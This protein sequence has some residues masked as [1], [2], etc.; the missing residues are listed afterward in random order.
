MP[1]AL[2]PSAYLIQGEGQGQLPKAMFSFA[3]SFDKDLLNT[4]FVWVLGEMFI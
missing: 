1:L 4:Y 2:Y 3:I